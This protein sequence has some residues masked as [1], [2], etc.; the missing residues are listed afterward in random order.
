MF[1][2]EK[3]GYN[4][5]E[6]K[7]LWEKLQVPNGRICFPVRFI[8]AVVSFLPNDWFHATSN[9]SRPPADITFHNAVI[10]QHL[11]SLVLQRAAAQVGISLLCTVS[12]SNEEQSNRYDALGQIF[13]VLFQR[14]VLDKRCWPCGVRLSWGA[15][16]WRLQKHHTNRFHLSLVYPYRSRICN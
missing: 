6:V 8:S 9:T 13:Y 12:I 10:T 2:R 16:I 4:R 14:L 1:T 5:L 3:N 7:L 15:S 11:R